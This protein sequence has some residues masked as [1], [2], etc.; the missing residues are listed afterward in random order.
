VEPD[1]QIYTADIVLYRTRKGRALTGATF[2]APPVRHFSVRHFDTKVT[3]IH[4]K[5]THFHTKVTHFH[6]P[7]QESI[8]KWPKCLVVKIVTEQD[9][10]RRTDGKLFSKGLI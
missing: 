6:A 2:L 10:G 9:E 3:H 7:C 5:M 4:T 8:Q 1:I